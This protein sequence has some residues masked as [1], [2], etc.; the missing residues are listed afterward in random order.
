VRTCWPPSRACLA[1]TLTS[2][3]TFGLLVV[4]ALLAVPVLVV[5]GLVWVVRAWLFPLLVDHAQL[6][7]AALTATAAVVLVDRFTR[8]WFIEAESARLV[9]PLRRIWRVQGW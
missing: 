7:A 2:T 8:P 9:D 5:G 1:L 4:V 6:V 3:S